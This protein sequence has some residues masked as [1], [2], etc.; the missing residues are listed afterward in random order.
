[1]A[2]KTSKSNENYFA[3]YK[4]QSLY[5]KNRKAKLLRQ[6]K[7][8]PGNAKQINDAIALLGSYRRKTPVTPK[9][10]ATLRA[11]TTII[12]EF[13]NA[14]GKIA[15]MKQGQYFNIKARAHTAGVPVW[16]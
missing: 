16:S 5:T 8:Q 3:R 15:D 6:L 11:E 12:N 13:K 14:V 2:Q 1:M 4:Q 10:N 7:L 9:W